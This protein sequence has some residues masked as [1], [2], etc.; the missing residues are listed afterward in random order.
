MFAIIGDIHG[1]YHTLKN[2]HEKIKEIYGD[3]DIY[4]TG[5]L[6]D[7]GNFSLQAIDYIMDNDIRPV[8]GN[9][10]RM[11]FTYFTDEHSSIGRM[12]QYNAC[13]KTLSD[14]QHNPAKLMQ[15]L[16][17][18]A[19]IPLFYD[20]GDHLL[21]H[22]G[23]GKHWLSVLADNGSL[24]VSTLERLAIENIDSETGLLWNRATI[25][26]VGK[27][28]IVGHTPV[29]NFK[30]YKE[31]MVY[32]IDTGAANGNK[33]TALV[34]TTSGEADVIF[35]MTDHRDVNLMTFR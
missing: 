11:F 27:T 29:P 34:K 32:Y 20:L 8:L 15:H 31:S 19:G 28:Q 24:D 7:R 25:L 16:D 1:C 13:E 18:I 17:F 22:A 6:V 21:S 9:H 4:A 33:L 5:D 23:V 30:F 26:N 35:V 14:Y 2:L 12:W 10:D 3:I